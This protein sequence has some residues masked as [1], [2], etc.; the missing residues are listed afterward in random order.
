MAANIAA[1]TARKMI[2]KK[3]EKNRASHRQEVVI[4]E[5]ARSQTA[6]QDDKVSRTQKKDVYEIILNTVLY[7]GSGLGI[8]FI[9]LAVIFFDHMFLLNAFVTMWVTFAVLLAV[10]AVLLAVILAEEIAYKIK[11]KRKKK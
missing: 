7:A 6:G 10:I 2:K 3:Y 4:P 11:E 1:Y 9:I 8:L 5:D